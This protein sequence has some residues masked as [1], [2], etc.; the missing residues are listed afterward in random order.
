MSGAAL[1]PSGKACTCTAAAR[2]QIRGERRT[3]RGR[4]IRVQEMRRLCGGAGNH[5]REVGRVGVGRVGRVGAERK[6]A[7]LMRLRVGMCTTR[8]SASKF[9]QRAR[10]CS[11]CKLA[12]SACS[13]KGLSS[14]KG[15]SVLSAY[16]AART[17]RRT[18]VH[19]VGVAHSATAA[20]LR[21]STATPRSEMACPRKPTEE[22]PNRH[23]EALA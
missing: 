17:K 1:R 13:S 3:I 19:H 21:G 9:S 4:E 16:T 14:R 10:S 18:S 7:V 8:Y 23:L 2:K 15:R 20:T 11:H 5:E 22:Q 6:S 12:L